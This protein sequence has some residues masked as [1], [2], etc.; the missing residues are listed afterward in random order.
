MICNEK[1][2]NIKLVTKDDYS[3]MT[4]LEMKF[5]ENFVPNEDS[6][7]KYLSTVIVDK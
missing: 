3:S 2:I 6:I 4:I 1:N 5:Y 7:N